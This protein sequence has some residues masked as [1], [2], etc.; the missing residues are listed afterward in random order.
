MKRREF[1]TLVESKRTA[2]HRHGDVFAAGAIAAVA[3]SAAAI[4]AGIAMRGEA[5]A[6][7]VEA[8]AEVVAQGI[9]GTA[10]ERSTRFLG[11][12]DAA[13]ARCRG[14]E[15][16]LAG[17]DTPW[18]DWANYWGTGDAASKS[19]RRAMQSHIFGRNRRGVDGALVDIERQRMELIKFNLSDNQTFEQYATGKIDAGVVDGATAKVWK[20]M[21]LPPNHAHYRGLQIEPDGTQ[22][23]KGELIRFRTTTGICN[24]IRNPAMGSTG[25]LFARNVEFE[26]TFPELEQD[27]YAKNRHG[28]RI[29]LL[30]PDPQ[31]IS[32]KLFTRDQSVTPNCNEGR[33]LLI[34]NDATCSYKKAPFFNVLAAFWIQF[35]THDWFS[36]LEDARNDRSRMLTSL[37]CASERVNNVER[38]LSA[39]RAAALGC[40]PED[41]MEAALIA[42]ETSPGSF[43][44]NGARR[45]QR[46]YKTT[47]N[48]TT[49]WW[50]ASQIYGYDERSRGRVRRDASDR[51]KLAL[52]VG[53][54]TSERYGYLPEFKSP[55]APDAASEPCDAIQPEW[56]GQEAV[57]FPDNWT[58]G[59]SF[60]HNLFVREHNIIV[61]SFQEHARREPN[62]DS[63]LRNP[64]APARV[65]TYAQIS[66]DELFEIARLIISAEIAKIHTTEWTTQLLY[67]E[68]LNIGMNSN[69]SGIFA[70]D[71]FAA[72]LSRTIVR[73]LGGSP[74]AQAA[75]QWYSALAAGAGILGTGNNKRFPKFL[76]D[77][78]SWDIW[79]LSN[80][81]H[82]NGGI[83]HFG[84]PF[85]FSEEFVSVY[86]LHP[87]VPD[88]LDF[89]ELDKPNLVQKKVPV[90][91]TF[92][93]K[94]T[95]KMREG[96]LSNWALTMG[97][98]RLGLLQLRNHPQQ[99]QN[100]DLRPRLDSKIDVAALDIIR[101]RERGI[102]RFNEFRRQI[103]LRTLRSFDNFVDARLPEGS[104]ELAEQRA[105]VQAIR[106]VYGQHRCDASKIITTAQRDPN[107]R[108]IDDCFGHPDGSMVDNIEDMDVQV[109]LLA[110][111]ARPH[112]FAISET[113]FQIFILN[114]SR[115]LFSDRFFTS[116][117]RPEFY[118]RFGIKWVMDNGPTGKQWEAGSPNS[119]HQEISPLKRVLL[120]A[121][122]E[123]ASELEHVVNAFDPWARDRS[124]YYSLAWKPRAD[125]AIDR[126]FQE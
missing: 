31:V 121:M 49:A 104:A 71:S 65:I 99:V 28:G 36:H 34:S 6:R 57:A 38:P 60:F 107:G 116:S 85:N 100:L 45:L 86:R 8:C 20:E 26:S 115:R 113:Q 17:M 81:D 122:P 58:I 89:R 62:A 12:V 56:M 41:K 119:H 30:T 10:H 64:S 15:K 39:E 23:C 63:G 70:D 88:L 101:D 111:M 83:N 120:R 108:P 74:E 59:L 90:I 118:T 5:D 48:N 9:P 32:R 73:M 11:K 106:E 125:T 76:P 40:R 1:I 112:G 16:A 114:A 117:F 18:V 35:M 94:A 91:E 97:R 44:H 93:G 52:T 55:C 53:S 66:E 82:V 123:L 25:Q 103:G 61:E 124:E 3:L 54:R 75:N 79:D 27:P 78:L 109:G 22:L 68:P 95:A 19:D 126:D 24:D 102:P 72:R 46:A 50:D 4:M 51:A 33:G 92:R 2:T 110:E 29:S 67:N 80:P 69:W 96:G 98:Q 37:G 43:T 7:I 87:L 77:W 105:I 84:S 14:G 21:R 42:E 13:H 47:R